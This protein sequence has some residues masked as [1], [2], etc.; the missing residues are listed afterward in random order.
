MR[1]I[2]WFTHVKQMS[3]S[4]LPTERY[5]MS[6]QFH[7]AIDDLDGRTPGG[8]QDARQR[9]LDEVRHGADARQLVVAVNQKEM[10]PGHAGVQIGLGRDRQGYLDIVPVQYASNQRPYDGP[11]QQYQQGPSPGDVAGAVGLGILGGVVAGALLNGGRGD[12][13]RGRRY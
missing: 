2:F 13:G 7:R 10:E 6:E 12:Y 11:P 9:L 1:H 4:Y 3:N 8:F 5:Q